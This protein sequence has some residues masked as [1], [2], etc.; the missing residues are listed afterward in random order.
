MCPYSNLLLDPN[1]KLADE[2]DQLVEIRS[3]NVDINNVTLHSHLYR[4][5]TPNGAN[6]LDFGSVI[7]NSPTVRTL[8]FE[9]LT[10][11]PLVL[12]L[13]AS[14]P[15]DIELYVKLED[16]DGSALDKSLVF[17]QKHA[18]SSALERVTSP[19]NGNGDLKERFMETLREL[20]TRPVVPAPK[21]KV[22]GL[23]GK[24]VEK[25]SNAA[26][27]KG[28][29]SVAGG[30]APAPKLS[31]GAA[32]AAAL[33]KGG[34]GR[35]VLLYG[36][37]V[38]FKDRSLLDEH[39]HLDLAAG[40][41]ISAH[42]TSPR[43]K[44]SALLDTIELEDKAKLSGQRIPKLD[45][46]ASAK[47]TGLVSKDHKVK[48]KSSS[49]HPNLPSSSS[50]KAPSTSS[51]MASS[52]KTPTAPTH[53]AGIMP[54]FTSIVGPSL[55][56]G[57]AGPSTPD[58]GKSPAL[59]GKRAEPRTEMF[60]AGDI[61]KMSVD[62][63]LVSMEQHD[64]R[65]STAGSSWTLEEE[66]V[67]V[68][69][70]I[71]LRKELANLISTGRLIPAR[72]LHIPPSSSKQLIVIMTP[73]GS[74]RPHISTRPKRADSRLFI[75]LNEFD[76]GYLSDANAEVLQSDLPVRDLIMRSN[77]VRSVLEVQQTSINMGNCDK[78]E[79][80]SKTIVIQVSFDAVFRSVN[81]DRRNRS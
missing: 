26:V 57:S 1:W 51:T 7:I 39:E 75:R 74:I 23:K 4:I 9:N 40:P 45:F 6:F 19:Q 64:A 3:K 73:N 68:K 32:V 25:G 53:T 18:D 31:I 41:P 27:E 35:P 76:R 29:D 28:S 56:P 61:S 33:K 62:N 38:M 48:K 8:L 49:N 71:S 15:E 44:I 2:I 54:S 36:N 55:T 52:P 13:M 12:S 66:E 34:R 58:G 10:F 22:K 63:L 37:A 24:E 42:R 17:K 69:Q 46:A 43:S 5:L 70:T 30:S 14:Q 16:C 65:R 67:F 72:A 21:V 20:G 78:G 11:A 80:K 81:I 47:A 60:Q 59:T 79:V 77:C 50:P